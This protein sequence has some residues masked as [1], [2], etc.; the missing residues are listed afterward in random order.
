MP[1]S[2]TA[3]ALAASLAAA[4]VAVPVSP[5]ASRTRPAPATPARSPSTSTAD[6]V[7]GL[8]RPTAPSGTLTFKV[9][10]HGRRRHRVLPAGR[11]RAAGH[12]RGRERRPRP[13]PRP[14][15][16][17]PAR[18]V[19]H[20]VQAGHGRRRDPGRVHR[21]RLG[22]SRSARRA[23][24]REQ[25]EDAEASY[26]AYVKDQ[27]GALDRGHRRRSPTPTR[28]GDDDDGP[29]P[30]RTDA[31]PLGARSSPS[32]SRSA[33]ST[34]CSTLREADLAEGDD[35]ER[36]APHREGPVA[37]DARRQRRRGLRAADPGGARRG[38]GRPRRRTPSSCVDKVNAP[39]FTFEAF[40]ISQ[41]RQGAARRGRHRQGHR[42]GGDLVAHRPVGLPGQRRRRAGRVRGAA[43]RRRG[44]GRRARR[45]RS[46]SGSTRSTRCSPSTA[47]SRP[48]SSPTTS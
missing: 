22:H 8:R 46:T 7:Q 12:L 1:R 34:R 3:R 13:H 25:L 37:A 43:R 28:A 20:G 2:P 9:T 29:R 17:G 11:G 39:D 15:R 31:R 27:A 36:L 18:H 24:S 35:L 42:R 4:L 41:R 30:V 48:A 33:T 5:A 16:P 26:V 32:R 38:R 6:R 44:R 21:D 47:R 19:L 40:Q 45:R 23:T 10:Q 14:R